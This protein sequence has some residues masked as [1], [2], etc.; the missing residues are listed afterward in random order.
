MLILPIFSGKFNKKRAIAPFFPLSRVSVELKSQV[1]SKQKLKLR[2]Q[3]MNSKANQQKWYL[4]LMLVLI[5]ITSRYAKADFIFGTPINLGPTINSTATE[6]GPSISADG[7]SLYFSDHAPGVRSDGHGRAD[8]WITT[9]PTKDDPWGVPM[10]LGPVVNSS[11]DDEF[12]DLSADGLSLYFS[13][14]RAGGLGHYDLWVTTRATTDD[15]WQEPVNLG[16]KVNSTYGDAGPRISTDGLSLYFSDFRTARPGG[17]GGWDCYVTTRATV[18]DPWGA[19]VNLGPVVNGPGFDAGPNVSAD[20]LIMFLHNNRPG[21]PGGM[22]DLWMTRRQT[23]DAD[24]EPLVN[25]GPVVNAG[26]F[27]ATPDISSDGSILY[28]CSERPDGFGSVDLW[29]VSIEPVCDF[30][31]DL[32]VDSADMHIMVDH[33]GENYSLC[34]IGPTPLGDGIVDI[35]DMVVLSEHLYRL[36]AHWKLDE[37]DGSIAYDSRGDYDGIV[38]GNP[39]WQPKGGMIDGSLMLDGMDDYIDTPFILDPSKGSF[40]VLAWVYCWMPGQVIIYQKGESGGTWLGTNPLGKLMTGFSDVNFG[41]LES[42][43]FIA[44]VQWHH[45]GFVYDTDTLHRRLYVDGVLVAED[46]TVV[47]GMPSDGGL[48]IGASKGLAAGTLFSGFIDDV[49][50]YNQALNTKEI[51]A[52]AQ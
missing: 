1:K 51:A 52:L 25:L 20:G 39:F 31:N 26:D 17:Y 4:M 7:L 21:G 50:I 2:R 45:V 40:S 22:S 32:K 43:S 35:Q 29:Q 38:N 8:L 10:N 49:R 47:S 42:E 12:P 28:F 18:S 44:D 41:A 23:P 6:Q 48:Y 36:T 15:A 11:A 19:P 9:R 30:N 37:A 14:N 33:W 16:S 34:D 5:I 24:W 27:D 13:S 3:K 46:T